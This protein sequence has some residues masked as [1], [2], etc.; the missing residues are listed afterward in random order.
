[1]KIEKNGNDSL[2][3]EH[4]EEIQVT[5]LR[6]MDLVITNI[7]NNNNNNNNIVFY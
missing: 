7:I 4:K 6:S 1:M 2:S 3:I 5:F